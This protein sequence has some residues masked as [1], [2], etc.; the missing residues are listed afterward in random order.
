MDKRSIGVFDSGV[1]GISVLNRLLKLL[2]NEN[3]IYIGDTARMPYGIRSEENIKKISSDCIEFISKEN[4]K[5]AV[6]ACNTVSSVAVDHLRDKFDFPIIEVVTPGT[7]DA[8]EVTKNKKIALIATD[9]TVNSGVYE[10]YIGMRD[11]QIEVRSLACPKLVLTIEAG[12]ALDEIGAEIIE[13]YLKFFDDF[14]YDTLVFACTHFPLA[15]KNFKDIYERQNKEVFLVDP[16]YNTALELEKT[17]KNLDAFN[18]NNQGKVVF[19]TTSD[20]NRFRQLAIKYC[21]LSPDKISPVTVDL[22]K[23]LRK[24]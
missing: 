12:H 24:K 15:R 18:E 14:D 7:V 4:L 9:V 3:Y 10:K 16:A 8:T 13:D 11:P 19:Y 2:P 20:P 21:R 22:E 17:L 1:G 6:I 5:A 23:A